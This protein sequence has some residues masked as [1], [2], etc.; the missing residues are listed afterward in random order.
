MYNSKTMIESQAQAIMLQLE[1]DFPND[2][3]EQARHA[4]EYTVAYFG[5]DIDGLN[6]CASETYNLIKKRYKLKHWQY[7]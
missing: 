5:K 7:E 3:E 4:R 2:E 1:N 6:W